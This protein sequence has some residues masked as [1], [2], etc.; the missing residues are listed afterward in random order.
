MSLHRIP[1]FYILQGSPCFPREH[2]KGGFVTGFFP[3]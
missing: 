3:T 1:T 2:G